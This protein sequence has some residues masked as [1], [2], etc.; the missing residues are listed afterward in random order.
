M[1][2][3]MIVDEEFFVNEELL[4]VPLIPPPVRR[5]KA[6]NNLLNINSEIYNSN[7]E[8]NFED[9]IFKNIN[10]ETFKRCN[11]ESN[12]NNKEITIKRIKTF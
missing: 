6:Y 9:N 1:S 8:L 2:F 10:N 7:L 4:N 3:Q 5:Q 12:I 11:S